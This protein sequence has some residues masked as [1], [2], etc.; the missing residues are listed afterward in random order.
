MPLLEIENLYF[1]YQD[2][3]LYK[4]ICLKLNPNDHAVLY[5][6]NGAGKTTLL[7]LIVGNLS[8]DKGKI[9]WSKG[10]TFSYLD[11]QLKVQQNLTVIDYLYGVYK[12]L[13]LK[14]EQM[15][16]LFLEASSN[17]KESE[18]LL[19]K[20]SRLQEELLSSNFYALE[21]KI[22]KLTDG[23]GFEK[24]QLNKKLAELSSGQR[25]KTYLAKMLLEE[26]DV[27][28]MDEPT[29]FLDASQVTFLAKYLESY[30][31][32]FLVVTHDQSFAKLIANVIFSLENQTLVRYKGDMDH[33]LMQREIDREQYQKNYE[34]QKRYIKREETFIAKHIVRATSARAAKSRRARLAHLSRLKAPENEGGEVSFFFPSL[35]PV[36]KKVLEVENL[37]IGYKTPLLSPISFTLLEGEKIAIIGQN[38]VGKT[39]FIKTIMNS[40]PSLGGK[41]AWLSNLKINIYEQDENFDR[42]L[43]P[44]ELIANSFPLFNKTDIRKRLGSFGIK[45]ELATRPLSALSG[46]EVTKTRFALLSFTP[47]NFLILDEPTNHLDQKAKDALFK[48]LSEFKGSFILVCHEKDFYDGLVD[49]ELHF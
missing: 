21:E 19:L 11:Q 2:K 26:N 24:S 28:I 30:P 7:E 36:G 31:N 43:S 47:S 37:I 49:Y 48:A 33:F 45:K 14:E 32:A 22:G 38:G 1:N 29:N 18:K 5:G 25:E 20:A 16:K 8:P 35:P 39:T 46:G 34:A 41:Y 12:D 42:A 23:L 4:H 44:F 10:V 15:E 13:F 3:E 9:T 27:L 17:E 40:I 6:I